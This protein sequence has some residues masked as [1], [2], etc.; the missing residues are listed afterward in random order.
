M[1]QKLTFDAEPRDAGIGPGTVR[2]SIGIED[3]DDLILDLADILAKIQ[4]I[5]AA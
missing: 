4:S 1:S 3:S 2:L 5:N